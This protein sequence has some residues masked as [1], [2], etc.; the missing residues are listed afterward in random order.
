MG[1]MLHKSAPSERKGLI[2]LKLLSQEYINEMIW[3]G[4]S[5]GVP[6]QLPEHEGG[7]YNF[8]HHHRDDLIKVPF[9]TAVALFSLGWPRYKAP[10]SGPDLMG[11]F[12][13]L[14]L[15]IDEIVDQYLR[16]PESL[17]ISALSKLK[18]TP[19]LFCTAHG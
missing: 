13:T 9:L 19:G 4:I 1:R 16:S 6:F 12:T 5:S 3:I 10:E 7:V 2:I 17:Q 18:M 11:I 14:H 15:G 8:L